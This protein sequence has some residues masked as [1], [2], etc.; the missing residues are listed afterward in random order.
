MQGG[1]HSHLAPCGILAHN[2]RRVIFQPLEAERLTGRSINGRSGAFE[3][4]YLGSNPSRPT[5][6]STA[7]PPDGGALRAAKFRGLAAA[8]TCRGG[9][10]G[11]EAGRERRRQMHR[12]LKDRSL[13]F[14]NK[15]KLRNK[16]LFWIRRCGAATR[17][18]EQTSSRNYQGEPAWRVST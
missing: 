3:A 7:G 1:D 11:L 2:V 4:L 16:N 5:N 10:T 18:R 13:Y 9:W 8:A 12:S 14:R 17:P 15:S 6:T